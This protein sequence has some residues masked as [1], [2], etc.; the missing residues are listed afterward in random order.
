MFV[1]Y[2]CDFVAQITVNRPSC[3]VLPSLP[4]QSKLEECKK[5]VELKRAEI[6]KLQARESALTAAFQASMGENKFEVFLTKVFKKQIKR[7]KK[8]EQRGDEGE[9]KCGIVCCRTWND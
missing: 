3:Y 1:C 2:A 9:T 6:A 7:V 4:R 5:K 8:K